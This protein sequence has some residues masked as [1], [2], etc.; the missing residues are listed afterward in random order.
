MIDLDL[1]PLEFSSPQVVIAGQTAP[2]PGITLIRGG[3]RIAASQCLV[4]HLCVRP[5]DAGQKAGSGWQPDGISTTGGPHDVWIDHCSVT[6]SCD[7]NVSAATYYKTGIQGEP[8]RRIFIRDCII[9]EGLAS[10]THQEGEHSK[11]TLVLDRTQEVA[12][13]R[14]LYCSNSQRNPRFKPD[15]S[16]V[17]V[18]NVVSNPGQQVM[19]FGG[20]PD[21]PFPLLSIGGNLVLLGP[22]SKKKTRLI[23]TG[24]ARAWVQDNE[25]W[26]LSGKAIE[27]MAPT[28]T[29]TPDRP[30]WPIG[31]EGLKVGDA[32]EHVRRF[33]GARPA[34]R[35]AI[36]ERIVTDA[37]NGTA[38]II[39]SQEEV[40]GYPKHARSTKAITVPDSG[41]RSW[42]ED[43]ARSVIF[44]E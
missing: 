13:V 24:R 9:A 30:V 19:A 43:L 16:G 2:P 4:Q 39:D 10:S 11:G 34:Q 22:D 26:D 40:G 44:K 5:G 42:L 15:T 1:K 29:V 17:I 36:D 35:D 12:I 41:R 25:G 14:N 37:F 18:G 32:K 7:E 31:L 20:D 27:I 38:K 8:A 28:I 6:W 33:A 21:E 3:L 23:M